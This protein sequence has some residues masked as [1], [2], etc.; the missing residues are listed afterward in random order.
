MKSLL[1]VFLLLVI[2]SAA[3]S[4]G[5]NAPRIRIA[6][7]GTS[8]THGTAFH[9]GKPDS[10]PARLQALV[11]A[12]YEVLDFSTSGATVCRKGDRPYILQSE[13]EKARAYRPDIVFIM[14]GRE[15]SKAINRHALHDFAKDY[16]TLI[17]SFRQPDTATRIVLL[18][19]PPV[20]SSDTVDITDE[21]LRSEIIP[22]IRLVAFTSGC[23]VI[24][25]YNYLIDRADLFP[26]TIHPSP[27]GAELIAA[28][29]YD[30]VMMPGVPGF[31][32]LKN[33]GLVT[34]RRNYFGFECSDFSFEG[35]DAKIVRPKKPAAGLPWLWRARFWGHEPQT[36]IALL[37]RG[38]HIA[39]LDVAEL[40]GNDDAIGRW[41][42]FYEMLVRSGLAQK[43]ALEAFS[44][45][46]VYAYRWAAAN[47][48]RVACVYADA[49]VLD[50]K[51]WP[52]GKGKGAG[53]PV[54]W[55]RFKQNYLLTEKEALAFRG[56]PLDLAPQIAGAGF[57]MLHICG[58]SDPVVP[59]EENTDLFEK[60]IL[61]SGG[62]ITVIRKRGV[63][64]H[65]HSL[66]NPQLIVDFILRATGQK[67]N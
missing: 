11:G 49:P 26:D 64:H 42:R 40:L 22:N 59:I 54:E 50:L 23:E 63:G 37:E 6:C 3:V 17:T 44:R 9:D 25:L 32:I 57:P 48:G 15:D 12:E 39:Y 4:G 38:F 47:P 65:P 67:P 52:G 14:L 58:D 21:V 55:E 18:L 43:P 46:G 30:V 66:P 61:E 5:T 20:F 34:L 33:A 45:G 8:I 2:P 28:R 10:Y 41:N 35:R 53:N 1:F 31:D 51:S 62:T 27:A 13:Y 60:R 19:P 24:N 29:L 7:I 36:E 56:N 16:E